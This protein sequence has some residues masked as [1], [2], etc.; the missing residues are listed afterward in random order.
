MFCTW[1]Q[2]KADCSSRGDFYPSYCDLQG[3]VY[4]SGLEKS[5]SKSVS[6]CFLKSS[7][8]RGCEATKLEP[9]EQRT[10]RHLVGDA[11]VA[12]PC[13]DEVTDAASPTTVD[14]SVGWGTKTGVS[15]SLEDT[16]DKLLDQ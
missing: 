2:N 12:H 3:G 9:A 6:P 14:R 10:L 1:K 4:V 15:D 5:T 13:T 11:A 8:L 16:I 7:R